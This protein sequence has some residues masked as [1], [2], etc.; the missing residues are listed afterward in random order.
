MQQS[1][2]VGMDAKRA[3]CNYRGL[4]NYSRLLIEGLIQWANTEVE[5]KLFTPK[6]SISEY[7]LWPSSKVQTLM[8]RGVARMTPELWRGFLQ[9]AIWSQYDLQIYHGLSHD[10]PWNI[11]NNTTEPK[12]IVTIHDLIF[13]RF[14][15][16]YPA[17]DRWTYLKKVK[18]SCTVADSIIA[19]SKQ[20]KLDLI[21]FLKVPE[22]KIEVIY[23]SIHPRFYKHENLNQNIIIQKS[24]LDGN[25][26]NPYFLY[27][28]AFEERKNILRLIKAFS[29]S[30]KETKHDLILIG[31]GTLKKQIQ[32]LILKLQIQT[33][34]HLLTD[35]SSKDLPL[36]YQG[37]TALVYPSLF[38]G[39]GLPIVEALFSQTLVLTSSGSCFPESAGP[40]AFYV[41]PLNGYEIAEQ[42][43]EIVKLNSIERKHLISMGSVH[44][45]SFHWK[46]T[47]ERL[48]NH[49]KKVVNS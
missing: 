39:F 11:S 13:L 49:Y 40:G 8:P 17:W 10:L 34:V 31:K 2:K 47:T 37:A 27:V 9:K 6:K 14:P 28:G 25:Q 24:I 41:D 20:T 18:H 1:L 4:G 45:S 35:V 12:T 32:E 7:A 30:Q 23:Q 16:L 43:K 15:E 46:K 26:Q 36:Y 44:C 42:L 19:I 22:D 5:L 3:Y 48:M 38:E 29:Q 21:E 33:K